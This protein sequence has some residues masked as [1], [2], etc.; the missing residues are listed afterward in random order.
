MLKGFHRARACQRRAD[1]AQSHGFEFAR[2]EFG[3][4]ISCP[5]AVPVSRYDGK[6]GDLRIAHEV[7]D[8]L[9]LGVG[10]SVGIAAEV[11]VGVRGTRLLDHSGGGVLRVRGMVGRAGA[12]FVGRPYQVPEGTTHRSPVGFRT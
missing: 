1:E 10:R 2:R 6:A 7:V 9:T 11:R 5:E 4:S 3:G 12:P 8:L